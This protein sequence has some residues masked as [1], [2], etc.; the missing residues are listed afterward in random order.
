METTITLENGEL[1]VN[2]PST[3]SQKFWITNSAVHA[4]WAIV[5]GQLIVGQRKQGV[6][7]VLVRIRNEDMGICHGVVIEDMGRKME[8]NGVDNGKLIFK[9]VRVSTDALLNKYLL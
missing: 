2:S 1:V 3:L 8:C 6:H 9:N 4:Q 7:A 5:F